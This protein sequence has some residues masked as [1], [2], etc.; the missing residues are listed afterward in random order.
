MIDIALDPITNDLVFSDFD[1]QL[2]DEIEQIMQNLA[3]RLRFFL[4][5]WYLNINIG[6]PYY[7]IFFVKAPNEIQVESILK[8]EIVTTRGIRELT[9]FSSNFDKTKR[10]FSIKFSARTVSNEE[11]LKE[12]EIPV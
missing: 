12:M 7:Q 1:F 11:I 4:A 6:L 9:S 2:V 8:E 5:E 3:V 10:V